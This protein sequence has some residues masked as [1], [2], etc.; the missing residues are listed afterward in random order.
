MLVVWDYF[1]VMAQDGFW[2]ES[3]SVADGFH[4]SAHMRQV[5]DEVDLG[6]MSWDEFCVEVSK[7]I[8]V[9]IEEV[10]QR[11]T[12][13][14]INRQVVETILA[15]KKHGH[16]PV[17][18]SNASHD[19]LL[20][21]MRKL[22]TYILFDR[23]FVSSETGLMKPDPDIFRYVLAEMAVDARDA[24]MV[25]DSARNIDAAELVGMRGIVYV[26]GMDIKS[27]LFELVA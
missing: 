15:L 16:T 19:Y 1:G 22:G 12:Q 6:H 2:Y 17:L 9:P 24:I 21:I 5:A 3:R 27:Q 18:L 7:D 25:D 4:R 10:E 23:I 20:P 14:R 11:F 8:R 26:P 13:H